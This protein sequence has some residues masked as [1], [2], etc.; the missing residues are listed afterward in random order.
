MLR[1]LVIPII[2]FALSACEYDP[3][4]TEDLPVMPRRD[5]P[6]QVIETKA[7]TDAELM[8]YVMVNMRAEREMIQPHSQP[9]ELKSIIQS[10]VTADDTDFDLDRYHEIRLATRNSNRLRMMELDIIDEY[11]EFDL[12]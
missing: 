6:A 1:Y 2:I 7:I 3:H 8:A 10:V 11:R 4:L 12:L 9:R 5:I